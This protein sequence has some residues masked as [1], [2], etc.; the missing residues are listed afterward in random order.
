MSHLPI[1]WVLVHGKITIVVP[2]IPIPSIQSIERHQNE[3]SRHRN[4]ASQHRKGMF[5]GHTSQQMNHYFSSHQIQL[6]TSSHP[7]KILLHQP[8]RS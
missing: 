4:E 8:S 6:V 7:I 3:V 1:L 2:G 5:G